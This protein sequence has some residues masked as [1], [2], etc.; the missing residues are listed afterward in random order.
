MLDHHEIALTDGGVE[1]V[2][3]GKYS[4]V[5]RMSSLIMSWR[6]TTCTQQAC[7]YIFVRKKVVSPQPKSPSRKTPAKLVYTCIYQ[8]ARRFY[9]CSDKKLAWNKR[10]I[11][12]SFS[13]LLSC[14]YMLAV[15]KNI[16]IKLTSTEI[17][18]LFCW[19]WKKKNSMQNWNS[20]KYLSL[21]KSL[22]DWPSLGCSQMLKLTPHAAVIFA[23]IRL[24]VSSNHQSSIYYPVQL[25]LY[26][27]C[28]GVIT[29]SI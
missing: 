24:A 18:I 20:L 21:V 1:F 6:E 28:N 11:F 7:N 25:L 16:T 14:S 3:W 10:T 2:I 12:Q 22:H 15:C 19:Q 4:Q 27:R 29:F 23:F 9:P 17:E 26:P 13:A 8:K 5:P